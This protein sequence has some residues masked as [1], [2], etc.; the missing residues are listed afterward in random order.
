M[1]QQSI[2]IRLFYFLWIYNILE[3]LNFLHTVLI[4]I[5]KILHLLLFYLAIIQF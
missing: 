1:F 4:Q 3:L 2:Q 5:L